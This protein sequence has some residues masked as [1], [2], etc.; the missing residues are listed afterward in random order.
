VSSSI[1]VA[2]VTGSF[3]LGAVALTYLGSGLRERQ[4]RKHDQR[5]AHYQKVAE[6]AAAADDLRQRVR[7]YRDTWALGGQK[8]TA[9]GIQV[10]RIAHEL[11]PPSDPP[12]LGHYLLAVG[13]TTVSELAAD[14]IIGKLV[15]SAGT[16][17]FQAVSPAVERLISAT[18]SLRISP[19]ANLAAAARDL[20]SAAITY[21]DEAK[22]NGKKLKHA[23]RVFEKSLSRFM[24]VGVRQDKRWRPLG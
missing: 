7:L 23:D 17:Y 16:M 10:G 24:S 12:K 5:A 21:A 14:G 8:S 15:N 3:T 11:L 1:E 13:L 22:S 2:I 4:R 9:V 19:D 20:A 6:V 18:A